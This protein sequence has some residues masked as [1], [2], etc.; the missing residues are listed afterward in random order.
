[1]IIKY[2]QWVTTLGTYG[3]MPF[4]IH[5]PQLIRRIVLEA[6]PRLMCRTS[7]CIDTSMPLQNSMDSGM[8]WQSWYALIFQPS[9]KL[10]CSPFRMGLSSC[11]YLLFDGFAAMLRRVTWSPRLLFQSDC[12]SCLMSLQPFVARCR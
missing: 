3:K 8:T 10:S 2:S 6:F 7:F 11:Q 5:L 1:M 9:L 12:S 4:K